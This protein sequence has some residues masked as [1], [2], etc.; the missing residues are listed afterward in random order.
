MVLRVTFKVHNFSPASATQNTEQNQSN[1]IAPSSNASVFVQSTPINP[2]PPPTI[3]A[4]HPTS[5]PSNDPNLQKTLKTHLS[6]FKGVPLQQQQS[7]SFGS[8]CNKCLRASTLLHNINVLSVN[9]IVHPPKTRQYGCNLSGLTDANL[10]SNCYNYVCQ[11][12]T[13][14]KD[15]WPSILCSY[16]K[17]QAIDSSILFHLLKF[18]STTILELYSPSWE[19]FSDRFKTAVADFNFVFDDCTHRK[20]CIDLTLLT[21]NGASIQHNFNQHSLP[22]VVCPWGCWEFVERC[23]SLSFEHFLALIDPQFR[24]CNH[25]EIKV[26]SIVP[27]FPEGFILLNEFYIR[28][29]LTIDQDK[30]LVVMTCSRHTKNSLQYV[31]PPFN[32]TLLNIS[33]NKPERLAIAQQQLHIVKT[34]KPK[35]NSHST[36]LIEERGSFSGVSSS[37]LEFPTFLDKSTTLQDLSETLVYNHR[38]DVQQLIDHY[39]TNNVISNEFVDFLYNNPLN[40]TTNEIQKSL[41]H[42]TSV[43]LYDAFKLQMSLNEIQDETFNLPLPVYANVPHDTSQHGYAPIRHYSSS[44]PIAS[45]MEALSKFSQRFLETLFVSDDISTKKLARLLRTISTISFTFDR[46]KTATTKAEITELISEMLNDETEHAASSDVFRKLVE[47]LQL[48]SCNID[49]RSFYSLSENQTAANNNF[50]FLFPNTRVDLDCSVPLDTLQFEG[51]T[52]KLLL[53][54]D[55]IGRGLYFCRHAKSHDGWFESSGNKFSFTT[56]EFAKFYEKTMQGRWEVAVYEKMESYDTNS[57]SSSFLKSIGGQSVFKCSNHNCW[58]VQKS[59]KNTTLCYKTDCKRLGKWVCP[60]DYCSTTVCNKHFT[61]KADSSDV[62]FVCSNKPFRQALNE[63]QD[64]VGLSCPEQTVFSSNNYDEIN[65]EADIIFNLD[66]YLTSAIDTSD[67]K[68]PLVTNA[69]VE[70]LQYELDNRCSTRKF[71][72]KVL[73]NNYLHVLKR[74]KVPIWTTNSHKNFLQSIVAKIPHTSVPLLYPES[75]LFP[76]IFW[77]QDNDGT[78]LGALPSALLNSDEVNKQLGFASVSDHLWSR[79]TNGALLTSSNLSYAS[80]AFDL[81]M[82]AELNKNHSTYIVFKRGFEDHLGDDDALRMPNTAIKWDGLESSKRVQEV[83]AACAEK[84]PDYFLTLT[85]SMSTHF[86]MKSL[87]AAIN[88]CFR[89][90]DEETYEAVVQSFMGLFTRMWERVSAVVMHYIEKSTEKPLGDVNRIWWRYEFQTT[91]GNLPHI[92]CLLW[93]NEKKTDAAFQ[94]RIVAKKSQLLYD[95]TSQYLRNFELIRDDEHAFEVYKDA[96]SFHHHSCE[97]TKFRCHKKTN[98]KGESFCR[99]PVYPPSTNYYHEEI[100]VHHSDQAFELL[101]KCGLAKPKVGFN[102]TLCVTEDL[103]AGQWFYPKQKNENLTPMNPHLFV[104]TRS[105]NNLLICDKYLS[106]R[107]IAKYAAGVEEKA[108]VSLSAGKTD[109][110]LEVNVGPIENTKIASVKHRLENKTPQ[111]KEA[112]DVKHLCITECYWHLFDLPFVRSSFASICVHTCE[113]ESRPGVKTKMKQRKMGALCVTLRNSLPSWRQ[114]TPSQKKVIELNVENCISIS[115]ITA[116]S[117]RPPE[118]LF[119]KNPRDYFWLFERLVIEKMNQMKLSKMLNEGALIDGFG[120]QVFIRTQRVEDFRIILYASNDTSAVMLRTLLAQNTINDYISPHKDNRSN[121]VIYFSKIYPSDPCK[122]LVHLLLSMGHF[123][124][125]FDLFNTNTLKDSFV[126]SGLL[127]STSVEQNVLSL[128]KKYILKQAQFLPGSTRMF[129]RNIIQCYEVLHDFLHN[130]SIAQLQPPRVLLSAVKE[131]NSEKIQSFL[132]KNRINVAKGLVASRKVFNCPEEKLLVNATTEKPIT[133]FPVIQ[134]RPGQP[135]ASFSQQKMVLNSFVTAID[136][137][138]LALASS[139]PH[140]FVLGRPGTGKSTVSL[141]ALCY[142]MSKGLNCMITTLAAEKSASMGGLHFHRLIPAPVSSSQPVMKQ[143]ESTV[144][145]LYQDPLRLVLLKKL[146]VLVVEELGMLNS[147]QWAILDQTLR[148][149]NDN[150][151]PMGGVLVFGNGDPK[152]LRPP[153]GPLIWISPILLTSF[154]FFY[155]KDYVRMEDINGA[156]VLSLLDKPNLTED[157]AQEILTIV[158]T[159][160]HFLPSW[161][162]LPRDSTTLRVVPTRLAEKKLVEEQTNLIK[163]MQLETFTAVSIDEV[164]RKGHNIWTKTNDSSISNFLSKTCLEPEKLLFYVGAPMRLTRNDAELG[165][166]QGQLC[167]VKELPQIENTTITL[168]VAPPCVREL[169]QVNARGVRDYETNNW[170][171]VKVRKIEGMPQFH[172]S[173]AFSVRR[174]QYPLKPFEASTIHKCIGDDVPFLATQIASS[175]PIEKKMFKLWEK[176]QLLVILSRVKQLKH[177]TFIGPKELTLQTMRKIIFNV[178]Q[179]DYFVDQFVQNL[180]ESDP[181]TPM[182]SYPLSQHVLPMSRQYIPD[183]NCASLF[184]L[185]SLKDGG[186]HIGTSLNLKTTLQQYNSYSHNLHVEILSR[187]PWAVVCAAFDVSAPTLDDSFTAM[188]LEWQ[189]ACHQNEKTEPR[190]LAQTLETVTA[191]KKHFFESINFVSFIET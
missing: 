83:A 106:A 4:S 159:H 32:P 40:L 53:L 154:T 114:F 6:I 93:V 23:H 184:C 39:L 145:K 180:S 49:T 26:N 37:T 188:Q 102:N 79:L 14:F 19:H 167:V 30:N 98:E 62:E 146:D 38:P 126:N 25:V 173:R 142:A 189:T 147:E 82:N 100:E 90:F 92:H 76:S 8:T 144:Q 35:Y 112:C 54:V 115:N 91:Q 96:V 42:S 60:N 70:L 116:H 52:Y 120:R 121:C 74:S 168:Y 164:S 24:N 178:N 67:N 72:T 34:G 169:P 117:A 78:C 3:N 28:P 170:K 172:K 20:Q 81:K 68:L 183:D 41:S 185:V 176:N 22:D 179:W 5:E 44:N 29:A 108:K 99:Y 177:I 118:L 148:F 11:D 103:K 137:Y 64:N 89:D 113:M 107:Y 152:Q 47:R 75:L 141:I 17:N 162:S 110:Q 125:E 138:I 140:H 123:E 157:D 16:W 71:P 51:N 9:L 181:A 13:K 46:Q 149:V 122:F 186:F 73:L 134:Q 139:I 27:N 105:Q 65:D 66:N 95:L 191:S 36:H 171:T 101:Q 15:S 119:V 77:K 155:L 59:R 94:N 128:T 158:S 174:I 151:T 153:S 55:N 150:N 69:G 104:V 7:S 87:F 187:K 85:C 86:G 135:D 57:L 160:C 143:V 127:T 129:D 109:K 133:F 182:L 156:R 48:F 84:E 124:T 43:S 130:H 161:S 33:P 45:I 131:S 165:F 31:H 166:C 88:E 97:A 111:K 175:N 1:E 136:K 63:D 2:L 10:C 18:L 56:V 50:L 190:I 163:N 58:L 12:S 132:S 61:D 80:L 21:L